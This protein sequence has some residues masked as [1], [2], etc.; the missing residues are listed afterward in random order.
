MVKIFNIRSLLYNTHQTD[1][2][3]IIITNVLTLAMITELKFLNQSKRPYNFSSITKQKTSQNERKSPSINQK[4]TSSKIK[5][6][7]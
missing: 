2:C 4:K 1:I 3:K 7:Y 5:Y 6:S